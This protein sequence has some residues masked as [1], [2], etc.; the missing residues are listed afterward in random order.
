M[1]DKVEEKFFDKSNFKNLIEKDSY[2]DGKI[3]EIFIDCLNKHAR[4]LS[5]Y[6]HLFYFKTL[7]K[8]LNNDLNN[9]H[10]SEINLDDIKWV[11]KKLDSFFKKINDDLYIKNIDD[12]NVFVSILKFSEL[13]LKESIKEKKVEPLYI[14]FFQIESKIEEFK[15]CKKSYKNSYEDD[16]KKYEFK[17]EIV[18]ISHESSKNSCM[19]NKCNTTEFIVKNLKCHF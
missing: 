2:F 19:G 13:I 3:S 5:Y 4:L 11:K 16:G 1:L 15:L 6:Y 12:Y 9:N 17:L 18:D 14:S 7:N 10:H 8:L